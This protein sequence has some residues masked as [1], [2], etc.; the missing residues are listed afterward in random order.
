MK[1]KMIALVMSM[2]LAAGIS[3]T[4][5]A[6]GNAT[7][8]FTPEKTLEYSGIT[9]ENG[10]IKLGT[11]FEGIAPGESRTQTITLTNKNSRT[12]DFYISA[13]AVEA[14]EKAKESARGA[15]YEV[16]LYTG[17]S[18]LY[19]SAVGGY[20]DANQ[21]SREGLSEMKALEDYVLIAT[22]AKGKS[23]DVTLEIYFDGEGMDNTQ[24]VDYSNALGQFQF[25]F[26][27]GYQ[28]PSSD[29][30]VY[31]EITRQG[32][33][34]QVT[35]YVEIVEERVPLSAA[36]TADTAMLG[37]GIAVLAIGIVMII[38]AARKKKGDTQA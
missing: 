6:E 22:L 25:Q 2:L 34:E 37:I 28:D 23:Q 14:L 19:D 5:L 26:R 18:V 13:A 12:A 33:A 4:V 16:K 1:K 36:A 32:E 29:R 9:E 20:N 15:G 30:V 11:E 21:G 24:S 38:L 27:A 35:N 17:S 10:V 8:T 7:V 31:R 3:G